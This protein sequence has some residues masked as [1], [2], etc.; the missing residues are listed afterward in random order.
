[1]HDAFAS[2][3]SKLVDCRKNF[4]FF[5]D[6][7]GKELVGSNA[8]MHRIC[9]LMRKMRVEAILREELILSKELNEER[10]AYAIRVDSGITT[11]ARAVRFTF[12]RKMPASGD[13]KDLGNE[14]IM[15][16]AVILTLV[17]KGGTD[18]Y[19]Y[20]AVVRPP[21][22]YI[23]GKWR[24]V[25]NYYVHC[26]KVFTTTVGTIASQKQFT[27]PGTFFCQ[28]NGLTHVCAHAALRIALNNWPG[29]VGEKITSKIINDALG[30]DHTTGKQ[31]P[32]GGLSAAEI[33]RVVQKVG[34][35]VFTAEFIDNP[36]ID[37]DEFVYPLIES[38]CPVVLG[39]M[40]PGVAHVVAVLG[41]TLNSD[42]WAEARHTY[43]AFPRYPYIPTASW[44][45]HFI[46]S[47]D[48]FGM[49]VTLPTESIRNLLVPKHNPNLHAALAVGLTP[50][51]GKI[52]GY[53]AEQSA[54]SIGNHII[55]RTAAPTS[56]RWLTH[57]QI[58]ESPKPGVSEG[59]LVNPI[60]CRTMMCLKKQYVDLMTLA[61]DE[62][63]Y[64]LN[65]GEIDL[66]NKSLPDCFWVT[67][68]T[69][70]NLYSGNKHKLG[71]IIT[72]VD[73]T[74]DQILKQEYHCF[75]WLTGICWHGPGLKNAPINWSIKGHIPLIRGI[76]LHQCENEW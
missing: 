1:M 10:D 58:R 63:N 25:S 29:Y 15:G 34:H 4:S 23:E 9:T 35:Q 21:S 70:A 54:A 43:G 65:A 71:D 73:P 31:I 45:D 22:L 42:R 7:I 66:L 62:R 51:A 49:Y 6:L 76:P 57:L 33:K 53:L 44:T 41:H 60:V 5:F 14:D 24:T 48:N 67:E 16:Y 38:S 27:F 56:N 39:I 13:W 64:K 61:E 8:P 32:D 37:Y 19:V 55:V 11:S 17:A 40:G 47:D 12:F 28:Q 68:I 72:L 2:A 3:E 50:L 20:E 52:S 46:V 18:S 59:Q 26:S 69:T 30:I 75:A 36:G 74:D